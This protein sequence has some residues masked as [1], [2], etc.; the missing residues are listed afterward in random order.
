VNG[1]IQMTERSI[2]VEAANSASVYERDRLRAA[3]TLA[4]LGYTTEA[5]DALNSLRSSE[6]VGEG[7]RNIA[8]RAVQQIQIGETPADPGRGV[9]PAPVE[10]DG[11]SPPRPL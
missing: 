7:V 4:Q 5:M 3:I 2:L 11:P 6:H 10:D 1:E 9:T 8:D